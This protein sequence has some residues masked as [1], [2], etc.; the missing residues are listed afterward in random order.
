MQLE[1]LV[2]RN[3]LSEAFP[4]CF[5]WLC[6]ALSHPQCMNLCEG[7]DGVS[8]KSCKEQFFSSSIYFFKYELHRFISFDSVFFLLGYLPFIFDLQNLFV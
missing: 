3:E 1:L 2:Y 5:Q 6:L 7:G 8:Y 4:H